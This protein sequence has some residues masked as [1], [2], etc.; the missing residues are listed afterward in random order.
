M[1]QWVRSLR[2]T[3]TLGSEGSRGT[4]GEAGP[5]CSEMP[6]RFVQPSLAPCGL[7]H[8]EPQCPSLVKVTAGVCRRSGLCR[9][10]PLDMFP[11]V[12]QTLLT[13]QG[14]SERGGNL[15]TVHSCPVQ[16]F[17]APYTF[18]HLYPRSSRWQL[19][20]LRQPVGTGLP[21][22]PLASSL[23]L[24]LSVLQ[25]APAWL[26]LPSHCCLSAL[27]MQDLP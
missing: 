3:G 9:G 17:P 4:G 7:R 23:T 12:S 25:T 1:G 24:T 20:V 8:D 16:R 19:E 26:T 13:R 5:A 10:T 2:A 15:P 14:G 6:G 18:T 11:R 27:L 21:Q 22:C